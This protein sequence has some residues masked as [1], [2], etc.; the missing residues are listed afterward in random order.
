MPW[1][2]LAPTRAER[3]RKRNIRRYCHIRLLGPIFIASL[4]ESATA[5]GN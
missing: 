2:V 3:M 5:T 1:W 4:A